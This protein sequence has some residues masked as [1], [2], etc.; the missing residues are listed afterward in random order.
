[1]LLSLFALS[2]VEGCVENSPAIPLLKGL[3]M[4]RLD[5]A[6]FPSLSGVCV[7]LFSIF[8]SALASGSPFFRSLAPELSARYSRLL[9]IASCMSIAIIGVIMASATIPAALPLSLSSLPPN[10]IANCAIVA[11]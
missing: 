4:K 8:S 5:V 2:A 7:A 6:W 11:R 3:I 10:I 1:M 9:D